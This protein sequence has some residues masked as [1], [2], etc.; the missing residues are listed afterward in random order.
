M[1]CRRSYVDDN[2]PY[3][4]RKTTEEV[5]A[6]LEKISKSTFEWFENNGMKANP[7]KCHLL[8]SKN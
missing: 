3:C 6:K 7:D 2:A 5:I 1:L 8:L 4:L